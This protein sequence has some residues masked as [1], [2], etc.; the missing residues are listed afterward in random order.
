MPLQHDLFI[1]NHPRQR[2]GTYSMD[3]IRHETAYG[4][5]EVTVEVVS[6]SHAAST[7]PLLKELDVMR[8]VIER[9]ASLADIVGES[10][11]TAVKFDA[12]NNQIFE[13]S[14]RYSRKPEHSSIYGVM[15]TRLTL[16][17]AKIQADINDIIDVYRVS[18]EAGRMLS[19]MIVDAMAFYPPPIVPGFT[20]NQHTS[21]RSQG[22][23]ARLKRTRRNAPPSSRRFTNPM[24]SPFSNRPKK[25]KND[26]KG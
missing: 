17:L 8:L 1:T 3:S 23:F 12:A 19:I 5:F 14:V 4:T 25:D 21:D 26:D 24:T 13:I 16:L 22:I 7:P 18:L 15:P 6:S 9:L 2:I 10:C 11:Q 20:L